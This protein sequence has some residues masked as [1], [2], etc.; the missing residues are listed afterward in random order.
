MQ[1]NWFQDLDLAG[2]GMVHQN[3]PEQ[4]QNFKVRRSVKKAVEYGC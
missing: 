1:P 3:C 2:E 4:M